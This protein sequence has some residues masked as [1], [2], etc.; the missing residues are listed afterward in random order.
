MFIP[1]LINHQV[2]YLR[3]FCVLVVLYYS[4]PYY[5]HYSRS[6]SS[7]ITYLHSF[8]GNR[9]SRVSVHLLPFL[10]NNPI[11]H[12]VLRLSSENYMF[13]VV[14]V[15]SGILKFEIAYGYK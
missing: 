9:I 7:N 8:L 14:I 6:L 3:L 4:L 13:F 12:N 11:Y 10:I 2:Y 5:L 1:V 15:V